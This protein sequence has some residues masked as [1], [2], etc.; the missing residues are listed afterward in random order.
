MGGGM[1]V[2]DDEMP[3]DPIVE[4]FKEEMGLG[5][6]KEKMSKGQK[7]ARSARAMKRATLRRRAPKKLF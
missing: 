1:M 3:A 7:R 4:K 2:I 6:D 5:K